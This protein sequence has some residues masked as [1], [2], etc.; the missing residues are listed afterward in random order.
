VAIASD[1]I[2][3]IGEAKRREAPKSCHSKS[4]ALI[5]DMSTQ[6]TR[7]ERRVDRMASSEQRSSC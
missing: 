7:L 3:A 2:Q 1:E 5:E 6:R 4:S